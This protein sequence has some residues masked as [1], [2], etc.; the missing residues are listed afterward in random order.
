M[1]DRKINRRGICLQGIL[2]LAPAGLNRKRH[3]IPEYLY[4][5][6]SSAACLTAGPSARWFYSHFAT[7]S[8]ALHGR[9][10]CSNH[11]PQQPRGL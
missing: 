10:K 4:F 11:A 1:T 3:N 7:A 6:T 5:Q 9:L 2:H 8:E